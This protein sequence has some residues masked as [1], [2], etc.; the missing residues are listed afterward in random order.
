MALQ[1]RVYSLETEYAISF[2]GDEGTSPGASAMV[3]VL[4]QALAERYG[5]SSTIYLVNGSLLVHDVGHAEWALPECRSAREAAIYDKA[6]DHLFYQVV[7]RAQQLFEAQGIHGRLVVTKNNADNYGHTY[8]CHENYQMMRDADLLTQEHF[9]RYMAHVMVPFLVSRQ[10]LVGSG[11]LI[12]R[13]GPG[14]A[15]LRYELAQRSA[16]IQTIVSRDTTKDRPIFNLGREGESFAVGN[17][18]RLHPILG[19]ANLSGWATWIKLGSTGLLLRMVEDLFIERPPALCSPLA[20]LKTLAGDI[21]GR[22][23]VQLQDGRALTAV[24]LQWE[25]YNYA[26][27]YL[28]LLGASDE[29]EALMEEWG[30]ALEDC[31]Q[32]PMRLRDRAD[33]AIK[34]QI[35]NTFLQRLGCSFAH[36]P[37]DPGVLTDLQAL[38]LRYHEISPDGLYSRLYPVDTLISEEEIARAQ[39]YPPPHTRA[40]VR[41]TAVR[42]GRELGV[43][44]YTNG[45]M[46]VSIEGEVLD[47]RDPMEI[48]HPVM[49]KW[50]H[51]PWK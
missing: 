21:T 48:D 18:R 17:F 27:A 19:D 7:P 14:G 9:V 44:V 16:F 36:P 23:K 15:E 49:L 4:S 1:D 43:T 51:A 30:R 3:D 11:R 32:D 20:A 46:D 50:T 12:T 47:L 33:W 40:N 45:W 42:L 10:L 22:E 29:D 5:L 41:G 28:T 35:L 37:A 8:G 13:R 26:D 34:K 24:E 25:Y 6:A 2:F 39:Q 38:D 31:E